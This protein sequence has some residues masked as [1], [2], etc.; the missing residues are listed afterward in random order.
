M[1]PDDKARDVSIYVKKIGGEVITL[2]RGKEDD[3]EV[4]HEVFFGENIKR[5]IKAFKR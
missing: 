4:T 5:V 3:D 1:K 2:K